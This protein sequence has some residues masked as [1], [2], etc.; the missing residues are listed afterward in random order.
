MG[1]S[2]I[3]DGRTITVRDGPVCKQNHTYEHA[4][5]LVCISSWR[6]LTTACLAAWC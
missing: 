5:E 2:H 4:W 6:I 1:K 3:V